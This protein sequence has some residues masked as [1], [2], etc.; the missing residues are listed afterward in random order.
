MLKKRSIRKSNSKSISCR[1]R[2]TVTIRNNDG[3]FQKKE[4]QVE[5]KNFS[6]SYAWPGDEPEY[7]IIGF[8]T[9]FKSPDESSSRADIKAGIAKYD[10]LSYQVHCSLYDPLGPDTEEW[11]GICYPND[12]E[13]LKLADIILFAVSKG[14][15]N[16]AITAVPP[17]IY[18]VGHFTRADIPAFGDFQT[19]S[20]MI[21]SVR[22]TFLSIGG[23]VAVDI[24]FDGEEPI[25]L[26]VVLRDTMLLTP[27]AS[28]SLA[29][30]GD[31]V[32]IPKIVLDPDDAERDQDLKKNMDRVLRDDPKLFER[33]AI[34]DAVICVRYLQEIMDQ[35]EQLLGERKA[36]P[37][38]TSIGVSLLI[39]DWEAKDLDPL[40]MVGKE[41]VKQR[42]YSKKKDRD[43]LP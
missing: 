41:H 26:A 28:K 15:E 39:A 10:L 42:Y 38:L 2:A 20:E 36:P 21:S 32:G 14:I 6:H 16:G 17:K 3:T 18:L 25:R 13:R 12:G 8:D 27:A 43:V 7:L 11:S 5:S 34:N 31:L 30:L 23:Y 9:E 35:C 24:E 19:L 4:V 22:S 29:A 40:E 33:Y 1:N 37:T